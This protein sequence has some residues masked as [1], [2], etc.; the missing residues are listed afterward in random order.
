MFSFF[1]VSK[2]T[3]SQENQKQIQEAEEVVFEEEEIN[4]NVEPSSW[5]PPDLSPEDV[6]CL[7]NLISGCSRRGVFKIN[8]YEVIL[9][10]FRKLCE[11]ARNNPSKF[12]IVQKPTEIKPPF[13]DFIDCDNN[14]NKKKK[15]EEEKETPISRRKRKGKKKRR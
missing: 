9:P 11:V 6:T 12:S 1:G 15:E 8:E 2:D 13:G 7:I 3:Q 5:I 14:K 10:V 4:T